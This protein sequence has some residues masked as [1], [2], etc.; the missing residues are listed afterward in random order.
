MARPR[1]STLLVLMILPWQGAQAVFAQELR[2]PDARQGYYLGGGLRSGL[3]TAEADV[4]NFGALTHFGGLLRFGQ[5]ATPWLGLGL[6]LGGGGEGNDD[7]SMT[8]GILVAEGQFQPWDIDL[9]FRLGAGVAGGGVSRVDEAEASDDDPDLV[10]GPM[11]SAGLSYDWF[12]FYDSQG[13]DSGGTSFSFFAEARYFPGGDVNSG[14]AFL[15][16][17]VTWWTGLNKRKLELPVDQA[18]D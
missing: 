9:A 8:Y 6:A 11:F 17:E 16:V 7:W 15:G 2:E 3:T 1:A 5:M 13:Y 14:G 18:F 12:P 10:F 4:G